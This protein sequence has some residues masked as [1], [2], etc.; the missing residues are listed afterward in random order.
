METVST[1]RCRTHLLDAGEE[2]GVVGGLPELRQQAHQLVA[3]QV[4]RRTIAGGGVS[5][6]CGVQALT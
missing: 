1:Q 6:G 2:E 5:G 4:L 3:V